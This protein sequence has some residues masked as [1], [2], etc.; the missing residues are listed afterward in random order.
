MSRAMHRVLPAGTPCILPPE[1]TAGVKASPAPAQIP[2][3]DLVLGVGARFWLFS[4]A[5]FQPLEFGLRIR[6]NEMTPF[7]ILIIEQLHSVVGSKNGADL[8]F[9]LVEEM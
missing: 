2:G 4:E 8:N 9:C 6:K 1:G 7:Q 5:P 3:P